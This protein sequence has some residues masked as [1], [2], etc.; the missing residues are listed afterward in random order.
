MR[1]NNSFQ[2]TNLGSTRSLGHD[3]LGG[4]EQSTSAMDIF[5]WSGYVV[6]NW[7][8]VLSAEEPS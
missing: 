6:Q 2:A 4:D 8:L 1:V 7:Y 3:K 5:F